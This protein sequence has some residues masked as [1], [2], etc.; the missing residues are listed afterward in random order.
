MK[1]HYR[2]P[3]CGQFDC[4]C[5]TTSTGLADL[6]GLAGLADPSAR[7]S[8]SCASLGGSV[9][10]ETGTIGTIGALIAPDEGAGTNQALGAL[11]LTGNADRTVR[12]MAAY[13]LQQGDR[14]GVFQMGILS[15]VRASDACV[16][17]A[18]NLVY[19]VTAGL[20]KLPLAVP[21]TL[22]ADTTYYLAV[23][24]QVANSR[25][26]GFTAGTAATTDAPPI[27]FRTQNLTGLNVGATI[28]LADTSLTLSPWLE[29]F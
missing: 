23:Y 13:I 3:Q 10:A 5:P 28:S 4:A 21:V 29:T 22:R 26:G 18:T 15:P 17:A 25:L 20:F 12:K 27:N 19:A 14:I 2:C 8:A 6:A 1:I 9:F 7:L 11:A 16:I 24:N